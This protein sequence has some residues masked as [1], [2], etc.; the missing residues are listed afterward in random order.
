MRMASGYDRKLLVHVIVHHGRDGINGCF[1]GWAELGKDHGEHVA[2][3][4]EEAYDLI[5]GPKGHNVGP[6]D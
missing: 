4:Y 3:V 6:G 2:N 1:C 5:H